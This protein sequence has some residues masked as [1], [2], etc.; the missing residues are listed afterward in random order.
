M[1]RCPAF[2][3]VFVTAVRSEPITKRLTRSLMQ[4]GAVTSRA[5]FRGRKTISDLANAIALSP[6]ICCLQ[7][8]HAPCKYHRKPSHVHVTWRLAVPTP[9]EAAV[10]LKCFSNQS[11]QVSR[12]QKRSNL[13]AVRD[14]CGYLE[15]PTRLSSSGTSVSS[16][17]CV[18]DILL[19]VAASAQFQRGI[20]LERKGKGTAMLISPAAAQ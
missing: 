9:G 14:R 5:T 1:C 3:T 19:A 12:D 8:R 11:P 18:C 13:T 4:S 7:L 16:V 2:G 6:G 20:H 17:H 15:W 10:V